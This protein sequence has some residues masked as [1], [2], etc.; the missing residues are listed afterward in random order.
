MAQVKMQ[1]T[2]NLSGPTMSPMVLPLPVTTTNTLGLP[3]AM[4]GSISEPAA[5]CSSPTAGPVDPAPASNSPGMLVQLC[6]LCC[7][8]ESF[9]QC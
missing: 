5:S 3:P 6:L 1:T 4:N 2:A 9:H 7:S 8:S